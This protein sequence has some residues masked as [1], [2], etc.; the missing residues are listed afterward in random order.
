LFRVTIFALRFSLLLFVATAAFASFASG[1]VN[2][3]SVEEKELSQELYKLLSNQQEIVLYLEN[4]VEED[5]NVVTDYL[6]KIPKDK[7]INVDDEIIPVN[8]KLFGL[9][10]EQALMM[11]GDDPRYS[12]GVCSRDHWQGDVANLWCHTYFTT[13]TKK[14]F[15]QQGASDLLANLASAVF[16]VPKEYLFDKNPSLSDITLGQYEIE[17]GE[18]K[19]LDLM[20]TPAGDI[21]FSFELKF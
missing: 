14:V 20:L 10:Q 17:L 9:T 5:Q 6:F 21:F 8:V 4:E 2:C 7:R 15:K 3:L 11:S 12:R 18:H 13:L 1:E 16:F 19:R